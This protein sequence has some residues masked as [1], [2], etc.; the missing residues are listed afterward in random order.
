[1]WGK[2][3]LDEGLGRKVDNGSLINHR[4]DNWLKGTTHFK[5]TQPHNIPPYIT[6]V[7]DLIDYNPC[8]WNTKLVNKV[9]FPLTKTEYKKS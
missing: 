8:S 4:K 5:L 9:F 3:L 7:L 2:S 1:M 6:K